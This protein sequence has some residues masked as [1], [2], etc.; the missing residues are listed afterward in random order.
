MAYRQLGTLLTTGRSNPS[1]RKIKK[2]SAERKVAPPAREVLC[3]PVRRESKHEPCRLGTLYPPLYA[4]AARILFFMDSDGSTLEYLSR[5]ECMRLMA[6]VPVGRIVYTRRALPAVELVNFALN[7]GD[8]IIKDGRWGQAR[9]GDPWCRGG[10][11]S[12]QPG[13]CRSYRLE[14]HD[15]GAVSGGHRQRGDPRSGTDRTHPVGAREAGS[16]HP[17]LAGHRARTAG[18]RTV[19]KV[20][21]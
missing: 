10:V 3:Q 19:H 4:L 7:D 15:R 20:R 13:R 18:W 6:S 2:N 1:V 17:D 21:H 9:R 8:I 11:R 5:D 14:C 12:R 16:L